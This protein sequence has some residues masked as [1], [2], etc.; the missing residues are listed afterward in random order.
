AFSPAVSSATGVLN[1]NTTT[2]ALPAGVY[3]FEVKI[4]TNPDASYSDAISTFVG[5]PAGSST[6]IT[7]STY[8]V[9]NLTLNPITGPISL[10]IPAGALGGAPNAM[11]V[12]VPAVVPGPSAGASGAIT[13]LG[14]A[15]DITLATPVAQF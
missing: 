11:T 5:S 1:Q 7:V 4:A 2:Y 8:A 12:L 15:I 10:S 13:P 14:P 3:Y 6:T 9:T